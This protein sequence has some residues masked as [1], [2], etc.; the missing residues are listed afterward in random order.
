L[1]LSIV[2]GQFWPF[3]ER[4]GDP[5]TALSNF[6][7]AVGLDVE[8]VRRR[9]PDAL[10]TANE[11]LELL[12]FVEPAFRHLGAAALASLE[13]ALFSRQIDEVRRA[14]EIVESCESIRLLAERWLP[15]ERFASFHAFLNDI[16]SMLDDPLSATLDDARAA[17]RISDHYAE[18]MERL[19]RLR[20]SHADV[21]TSLSSNPGWEM[22]PDADDLIHHAAI[23]DALVD[24]LLSQLI[25]PTELDEFITQLGR[26]AAS[27]A[28]F[29]AR[30]SAG[31]RTGRD[32]ARKGRSKG[33]PPD[34]PLTEFEQALRFFG[35][36]V[37]DRP[38]REEVKK[39]YFAK[40]KL[41][42]PDHGG[43]EDDAKD[44]N[45]FWDVLRRK[46]AS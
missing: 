22:G 5:A 38:K 43:R 12:V 30:A 16:A 20:R 29:A 15:E 24:A 13:Q 11:V 19:D 25:A 34:P 17:R 1:G 41:S 23:F 35:F 46:L 10:A 8:A 33:P 7:G 44:A 37:S 42:H 40:I 45:R 14:A 2:P 39:R 6:L 32:R 18:V 9:E 3:L 4:A 31:P 21:R 36:A 28:A 27:F 26:H